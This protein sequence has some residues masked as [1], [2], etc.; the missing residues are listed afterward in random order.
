MLW[1]KVRNICTMMYWIPYCWALTW[2]PLFSVMC[3]VVMHIFHA[4]SCSSH[5]LQSYPHHWRDLAWWTLCGE[6]HWTL[7]YLCPTQ[8]ISHTEHLLLLKMLFSLGFCDTFSSGSIRAALS[9]SAFPQIPLERLLSISAPNIRILFF[10][11]LA[12][13]VCLGQSHPFLWLELPSTCWF[14][15][16]YIWPWPA[17]L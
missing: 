14:L 5:S 12:V 4:R 1:R 9:H 16:L 6:I 15:I 10:N 2:C 11:L 17:G 8:P 13:D 3:S 7:V